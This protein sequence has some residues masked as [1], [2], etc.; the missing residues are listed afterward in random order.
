MTRM[1]RLTPRQIDAIARAIATVGV[2]TLLLI[3]AIFYRATDPAGGLSRIAVDAVEYDETVPGLEFAAALD[4][5]TTTTTT[6]TTTT[7]PPAEQA[8][9][10]AAYVGDRIAEAEYRLEVMRNHPG[11]GPNLDT[12]AE[13]IRNYVLW[14]AYD[15]HGWQASEADALVELINRE[16]S[17]DPTADNPRSTA[18]GLF[19]FLSGTAKLYGQHHPDLDKQVPT[20]EEQVTAGFRYI[21]DRYGTPSAALAFHDRLNWY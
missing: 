18:F 5:A 4:A 11:T 20:V 13:V 9:S 12:P 6:T 10:I 17:F 21:V 7:E 3:F 2:L 19:Q 14:R 15:E 16:S 8:P 1:N